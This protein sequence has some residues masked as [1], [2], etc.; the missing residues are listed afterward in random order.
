MYITEIEIIDFRNFQSTKIENGEVKGCN[1]KFVDG[2]NVIIGHNNSGKS[3]LIKALDLVLNFGGS[4]KLEIDDFNKNKT[5]A[6]LIN[7]PPKVKISVT[8]S[9][10]ENEEEFSDDLVTASTWLTKLNSPYTAKLTYIFYLPQK[11]HE[12]YKKEMQL[13]ASDDIENYWLAIKHQFLRKYTSK[14][15]SGNSEYKNVVDSE[16]SKKIDFQFLDAIRDVNRDLFTG[17]N[18]LLREV[19][20][21]FIDYDI[22][23]NAKLERKE[24]QKQI[25][26][27]RKDFSEEAKKLI[28]Q[29]Q[30]RMESGK[31]EMLSYASDTGAS[32]EKSEPD[33]E[34]HILD[35]ELYSAL[36][37]IVKHET[38]IT[39]P[40]TH[41]GLGYNNLIYI[42]LLL[43]KMQKD[44][45]GDY[46]GS[47]SKTFP[48]LVIEEPEAHLHP[49]MQYKF[50]K[51]LYEN[52][53]EKA[54]Q[55]FIT[56]HSPNITAAVNLDN[57][58]CF[59]R[60]NK[61]KLNIAY[62]GNAFA[63]SET[64]SKA[65]VQRFLDATKSDMLFSKKVVLVEGI[66]EQLLLPI[67]ANYENKSFE[68]E[69]VSVINI[70]GRYFKHFLKLF[71]SEKPNTIN[72]KIACITD[73]DPVYTIDDDTKNEKCYPFE[74]RDDLVEFKECSNSL[75]DDYAE[76]K[77]ANIR[78][79]S[80]QKG[81]GKTFEYAL[82]F[83]NLQTEIFIGETIANKDEL[84]KLVEAYNKGNTLDELLA[85][86]SSRGSE[87]SRIKNAIS[88]S[89]IDTEER[90]KH[91]IASRYLN[92]LSKGENAYE[93]AQI[94]Q[95]NLEKD[96]PVDFKTPIYIKQAINWICE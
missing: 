43:A 76:S 28:K 46:L 15:Y 4:K 94:L 72:K 69:H 87:N 64:D 10:S 2:V 56:T 23:S 65:Y 9:E 58:I 25:A 34:G 21:F 30:S 1:I 5:I 29:L 40:A 8:F 67:F 37:L 60:D 44:A 50:L 22:K 82:A 90:K 39:I 35:T 85:I 24:Q 32:F 84:K 27:K 31:K 91:L 61:G 36:K 68:D 45:S 57:I 41:N 79:F 95:A 93:L 38:G 11:E 75:V 13:I 66:T 33:F 12:D 47:N 80:Q 48:I 54:K 14:I 52:K 83:E 16:T 17:R 26:Q 59:N 96:N 89:S 6:Q 18:T 88:A 53:K 51:F 20:D 78:S 86:F 19:I 73:L 49:A 74:K 71:D 62:L 7:E 55:I 42:S 81:V 92:S 3:N 63:E 70:G 77:H